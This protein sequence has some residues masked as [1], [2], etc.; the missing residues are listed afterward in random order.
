M[1]VVRGGDKAWVLQEIEWRFAER[2]LSERGQ[3]RLFSNGKFSLGLTYL[4]EGQVFSGYGGLLNLEASAS[5][6]CVML[7]SLF[8]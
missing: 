4:P 3:L 6:N 7:L 2:G 5:F 1:M 8:H